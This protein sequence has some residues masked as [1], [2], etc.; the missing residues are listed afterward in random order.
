M[1]ARTELRSARSRARAS[2]ASF[3]VLCRRAPTI[4]S[5]SRS[6]RAAI[7][8]EAPAAARLRDVSRPMPLAPPVTIIALPVRSTPWRTSSVVVKN[9]NCSVED[10]LL[11]PPQD[12]SRARQCLLAGGAGS[13]R[14]V[15]TIGW[16][17]GRLR[18]LFQQFLANPGRDPQAA[19]RF[20]V[21]MS[22]RP[23]DEAAA[24]RCGLE[25]P[26]SQS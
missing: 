9:P 10:M 25:P 21:T 13:W 1:K 20:I 14:L 17:C 8:T 11:S 16:K 2:I 18:R 5:A 22:R 26:E 4:S 24:S 23:E 19:V 7:V 6:R 12:G 15:L 3:A